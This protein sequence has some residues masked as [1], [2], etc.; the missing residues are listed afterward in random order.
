M[1]RLL[2]CVLATVAWGC[3]G[4]PD[5]VA[6][7]APSA[8]QAPESVMTSAGASDGARPAVKSRKPLPA[9]VIVLQRVVIPDPGVIA[10]MTA[11]TALVPEG[12]RTRGGVVPARDLC[13]DPFGVDWTAT[14]PD[15]RS[16]LAIFPTESWQWSNTDIQSNCP[17][18][19]FATVRDYLAA[20][21]QRSVP[22]ARI[23]DF[24]ERPDFAKSAAE[25][26]RTTEAMA[27]QAGLSVRAKA[28]GGEM[29]FAFTQD[30]VEMRGVAG[31]TAVFYLSQVHNPMGGPPMETLTGA[32][33]GT[34]AASAP[35]G[36]LDFELIEASRRSMAP[37]P[38]WL[39]RLFALKSKLGA[40][41]VKGTADRAALI[42]AGGAAATKANIEAFREMARPPASTGAGDGAGGGSGEL[43]PGEA[44]GDR[45]Q[46]ESVEAIRGVET[47]RDPVDGRAVQLDHNYDHAW[48]VN[49]QEAYILTK[50]P[51]FN[52]GQYGIEATQMG[53]VR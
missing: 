31:A 39:E 10:P 51:N 36:Q 8:A 47:Y 18:G 45:M 27:Q 49:N 35:D 52:P 2:W 23:L 9:G 17:P 40:I 29:L 30:G 37:N 3:G 7:A 5:S 32:T 26:V 14:S 15:G 16:S 46:R 34:F 50:D 42:V 38:D 4:K 19:A 24:R 12:W 6:E 43:Y 44:A 1:R 13:S 48:R 25:F 53:V 41:A 11:L 20:H 33:V 21:L 22:G 28:E